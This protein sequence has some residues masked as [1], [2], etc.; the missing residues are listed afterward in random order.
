MFFIQH[1]PSAQTTTC[2]SSDAQP[3]MQKH[4]I[5]LNPQYD[6]SME[7]RIL[8][9]SRQHQK[10]LEQ[11]CRQQQ[12]FPIKKKQ[13]AADESVHLTYRSEP[14]PSTP[15]MTCCP[16]HKSSTSNHHN[17]QMMPQYCCHKSKSNHHSIYMYSHNIH[18]LNVHHML[19]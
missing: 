11:V 10:M 15:N 9:S 18:C 17:N 2:T 4:S 5:S 14:E 7:H 1:G 12:Q 3:D 19:Y 16:F 13:P 6:P 8:D